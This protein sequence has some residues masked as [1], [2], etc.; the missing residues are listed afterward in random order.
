MVFRLL[1]YILLGLGIVLFG[2]NT[3][4]NKEKKEGYLKVDKFKLNKSDS[5]LKNWTCYNIADNTICCPESWG[6]VETKKFMFYSDMRDSLANTYFVV[7]TYSV[8]SLD[9]TPLNYFKEVYSTLVNDTSEVFKGYKLTELIFKDK[10]SF[11]GEFFTDIAGESYVFYQMIWELDDIMYDMGIKAKKDEGDIYHQYFQGILYNFQK[12]GKHFFSEKDE[13]EEIR[14][15]QIED[16]KSPLA[17]LHG[18][19]SY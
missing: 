14:P 6:Y 17:D 12:N 5:N 15:I 3:E 4:A 7:N 18:Q 10:S 8:N 16:A 2:C 19:H 13:L 1:K 9:I 11:F